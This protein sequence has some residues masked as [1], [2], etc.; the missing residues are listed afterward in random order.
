MK[1]IILHGG[2]GTRLRP[3]THTGPKQLIPIA[4]KPISQYT[5]ED[6]KNSGIKDI[7][8]VLGDIHPEKVIEYYGDGAKFN[9]KIKYINQ[10]KPKGIA[11]AI[12]LC[13]N[14]VEEEKFIVYL[15]D[16]LLKGGI[17]SFVDKFSKSD[18]D[19]MILLCE[20]KEPQRFGVAEFDEKG[21]VKRLIERIALLEARIEKIEKHI[22]IH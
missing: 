19:A 22:G 4:N 9:V 20:V 5:L 7:A 14:F 13:K 15:G 18:L 6:L 16:N 21:K 3:L 1:G 10:G 2:H 12:S 17:K 8:I 11:H